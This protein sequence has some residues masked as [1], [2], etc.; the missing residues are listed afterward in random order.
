MLDSL[1]RQRRQV[2]ATYRGEDLHTGEEAPAVVSSNDESD[3]VLGGGGSLRGGT[4]G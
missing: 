3:R 1:C 2:A 4:W